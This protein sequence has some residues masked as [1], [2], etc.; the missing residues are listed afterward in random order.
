MPI[1][2]WFALCDR[3][4]TT[5]LPHPILGWVPCCARCAAQV[6]SLDELVEVSP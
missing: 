6:G 5:C 3:E 4:T 2:E 1:C